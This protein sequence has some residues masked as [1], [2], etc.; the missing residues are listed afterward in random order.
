MPC[1]RTLFM[2]RI[3]KQT[4]Q[5][6][7]LNSYTFC[8]L[9]EKVM[10]LVFDRLITYCAFIIA[11]VAFNHRYRKRLEESTSI[12]WPQRNKRS[13]TARH[14]IL[15]QTFLHKYMLAHKIHYKSECKYSR[16]EQGTRARN[17]R[18]RISIAPHPEQI[19]NLKYPRRELYSKSGP[20]A[21]LFASLKDSESFRAAASPSGNLS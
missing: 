6:N 17:R 18:S 7:L 19:T 20:S 1:Q 15:A 13:S 3:E 14:N 5:K 8:A 11:R 2:H 10:M 16:K 9:Q 12:V 4:L 21:G